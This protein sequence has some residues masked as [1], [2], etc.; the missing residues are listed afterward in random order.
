MPFEQIIPR[1]FTPPAVREYAPVTSGVYGISNALRWIYV[2][3]SENIQQALLGHLAE[4]GT[5]IL[6][7]SPTG[8][9]FEVCDRQSRMVRQG[10]LVTEYVPSCN[11]QA[12]R[13]R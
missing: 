1:S 8:F 7:E 13:Y 3:E 12:S 6:K 9:V 10:R 4:S 2:G 5:S 11:R